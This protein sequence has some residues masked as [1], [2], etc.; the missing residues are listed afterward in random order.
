MS[1]G[2]DNS[3][4][5]LQRGGMG[6]GRGGIESTDMNDEAS[7]S[8]GDMGRWVGVSWLGGWGGLS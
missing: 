3:V 4:G 8:C 1:E 2:W 5:E 6:G 7:D